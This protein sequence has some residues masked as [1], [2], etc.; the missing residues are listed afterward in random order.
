MP[1]ILETKILHRKEY[2]PEYAEKLY[3]GPYLV[4]KISLA[5]D[6]Q[7]QRI[8]PSLLM[9]VNPHERPFLPE[10]ERCTAELQVLCCIQKVWEVRKMKGGLVK[11]HDLE[12]REKRGR[13]TGKKRF[14]VSA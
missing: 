3:C 2:S 8:H 13:H 5:T 14:Q 4:V 7:V 6:D 12:P 9:G 10:R 11:E 1:P